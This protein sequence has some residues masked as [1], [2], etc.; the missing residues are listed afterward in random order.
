MTTVHASP[1]YAILPQGSP[2]PGYPSL[3]TP[4]TFTNTLDDADFPARRGAF[5][6]HVLRNLAPHNTKAVWYELARLAAGG[7][8]HEGVIFST[9]A[10]IA[11]R[12][13]CADFAL[14]S[15]LR[16]LYQ[17]TPRRGEE[18]T[19]FSSELFARAR[20]TVLAFKYFPDEPGIDSLCTWTENHY[21]LFSSA[22]Y[23]A[24]QLYPGEIFTNSGETGEQK[25]ALNRPRILRWLELRFR[26]GFSEWLSHVYY[27]EDLTALLS[28]V[29]FCQDAVRDGLED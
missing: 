12:K 18:G 3:P 14:H 20:Q 23:L 27:D 15:I 19:T 13:D 11:A 1:D 17:F 5:L 10:F 16:L 26:S 7:R 25:M 22:A 6:A 4:D 24:G 8:P 9:L 29:D 2:P 21:I 28:L